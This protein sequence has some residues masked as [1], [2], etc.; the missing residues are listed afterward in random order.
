MKIKLTTMEI[1]LIVSSYISKKY[2]GGKEILSTPT[3]STYDGKLDS[4]EFNVELA[5]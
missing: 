3:V 2:F 5:E 1:S 4:I